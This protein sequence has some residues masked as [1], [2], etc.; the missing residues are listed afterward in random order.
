MSALE[1]Q[2]HKKHFKN[3]RLILFSQEKT[4][5]T[6]GIDLL[7]E[8]RDKY[9]PK[10]GLVNK[11]VLTENLRNYK[12]NEVPKDKREYYLGMREGVAAV[13]RFVKQFPCDEA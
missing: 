7:K 4:F 13:I 11:K 10:K 3:A 12:E 2:I 8:L 6:V 5:D 9:K 1:K